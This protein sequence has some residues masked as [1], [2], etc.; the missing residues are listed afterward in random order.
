M[1]AG[2]FADP[3]GRHEYRYFDGSSW[4]GHVADQGVAAE[5]PAN[6]PTPAAR[7][8]MSDSA[9]QLNAWSERRMRDAAV[10]WTNRRAGGGRDDGLPVLDDIDEPA[11]LGQWSGLAGAV[12]RYGMAASGVVASG[13]LL[14]LLTA[15]T[16]AGDAQTRLLRRIDTKID[17]L[18]LGPYQTGRTHLAEAAR[19][20]PEDETQ[21]EH[22]E[23]AKECFYL[24]HGQAVSVQS[25]AL[26]EF[27][28]GVAWLL[29]TRRSDALY[30]FAQSY[31]SAVTVAHEFARLTE[32]IRVLH[33]RSSAAAAS[34]YFPA[35]VVVLGMKFKKVMAAEQ[36]RQL[37]HEFLPFVD[38]VARSHN[39][40][41]KLEDVVPALQLNP[42]ADGAEL[43][44]VPA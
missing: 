28:L 14:G 43:V 34:Y 19:V 13:D 1:T 18:V 35:G 41:A 4:T 16:G 29:L 3:Y 5:E 11:V 22:I 17:A 10:W 21:H 24:A 37:L 31:A 30:W 20:G 23:Q 15:V 12:T 38:C 9:R 33:S 26:V 39:A 7:P 2:W 25:R 32:N 40:L 6:L 44:E 8:S 42:T 36:A 27:H